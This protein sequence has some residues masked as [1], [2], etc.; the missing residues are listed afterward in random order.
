MPSAQPTPT[1]HAIVSSVDQNAFRPEPKWASFIPGGYSHQR[2]IGL[3]GKPLIWVILA[4]SGCAILFFGY[5][6]GVMALVNVNPDY[7]R[8]MGTTSGTSRD[9]AANGGLVSLWFGGFLIGAILVG[10]YADKIGRLK[11]MIVGCAW[12]AFGA[13]LQASAQN[14]TWMAFAR[15][16]GG[17]GCGHLNAVVPIWT[18]ELADAHLRGA[19]VAVEF[20]LA[21]GGICGVY[22][23]EYACLKTQG[24]G[25]AWRFPLALQIVFLIILVLVVPFMVESPRHLAA[26]ARY[27]EARHVLQKARLNPSPEKIEAEM[28]EI[29]DA[30]RLE[31][32]S[33]SK[34][35]WS[36]L[37]TKDHLHTRRRLLL[38]A[39]VQVMQKF[40][41]I[42]FI[43]TYAPQMFA[44]SGYSGTKSD[45]LAGGNLISYTAS[46]AL[47]IYL[48]DR[49]GRRKLMLIGCSVMG[50]LLIV[51]GVLAHLVNKNEANEAQAQKFGA[52]VAAV[53]Y[54]YTFAYGS[55][56]LTVCWV[57]PTEIF[58]LASRAKGVAFA[59]IA[60][61]IAGGIVNEI[62]PYLIKA[63]G[64]WIFILFAFVNFGMLVPIF[65]FYIETAGRHLEDLDLLF[66]GNSNIAW[67]AE[68]E[69]EAEKT[70]LDKEKAIL[71]PSVEQAEEIVEGGSKGVCVET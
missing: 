29:L 18:S 62:T 22:W 66:A 25:F 40:T 27:H 57:Y 54:L 4:V 8:N 17:I 3:T 33:T 67:R 60:F 49:V 48:I 56:W 7:L 46:L 14:F 69:Y 28:T 2:A 50:V 1:S 70:S 15:I 20:T 38:G 53:L 35:Y 45:I 59:T 55:T 39:G 32:R 12:A 34:S 36:M 47:S 42:D 21:V 43:T 37:F 64:F 9:A 16:I 41:G 44:L 58:P 10:L 61:S 30:I 51:G 68:K 31:A 24:A 52:G 65:L 23:I 6:A 11:T 26:T 71:G 19:F 13:A 5:D 63:I